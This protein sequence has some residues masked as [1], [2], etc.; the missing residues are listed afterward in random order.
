[1]LVPVAAMHHRASQERAERTSGTVLAQRLRHLLTI[2]VR[3][4]YPARIAHWR[5]LAGP[6][7]ISEC[8]MPQM[9][10]LAAGAS[11]E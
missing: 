9:P 1:M 3:R 10:G 5:N 2:G 6:G 4:A 7:A 8:A 11:P